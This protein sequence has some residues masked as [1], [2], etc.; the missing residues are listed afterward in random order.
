M[1]AVAN[2]AISSNCLVKDSNK[3]P[4]VKEQ[5][6]FATWREAAQKALSM[7][8]TGDV[9]L[10]QADEVDESVAFFREIAIGSLEPKSIKSNK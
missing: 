3:A 8:Q 7:A 6:G 2:E 10:I 9:V 5:I 4:R 1:C